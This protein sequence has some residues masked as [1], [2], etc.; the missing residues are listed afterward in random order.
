M[1]KENAQDPWNISIQVIEFL[2]KKFAMANIV[3]HQY[4][5]PQENNEQNKQVGN[6]PSPMQIAYCK[7]QN[8]RRDNNKSNF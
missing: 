5:R 6:V 3:Q 4:I 1:T 2:F 7:K 8:G